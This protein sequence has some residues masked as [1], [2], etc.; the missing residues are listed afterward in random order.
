MRFDFPKI[1]TSTPGG[2]FHPFFPGL[3]HT[4]TRTKNSGEI[5]ACQA[6]EIDLR[7]RKPYRS[8]E[9]KYLT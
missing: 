9:A 2:F 8:V 1:D 4:H 6:D 5:I 7:P 3:Q